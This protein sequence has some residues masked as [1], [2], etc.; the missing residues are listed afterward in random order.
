MGAMVEDVPYQP[1]ESEILAHTYDG[2]RRDAYFA[3]AINHGVGKPHYFVCLDESGG[4]RSWWLDPEQAE[5]LGR[6][7]VKCGVDCQRLNAEIDSRAGSPGP[8]P[9]QD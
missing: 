2:R 1:E 5:E 4:E 7:L 9:A 8:G 3:V 6:M